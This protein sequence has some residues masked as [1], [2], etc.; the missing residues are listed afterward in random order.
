MRKLM[1]ALASWMLGGRGALGP[2]KRWLASLFLRHFPG[3][4]TCAEF[5]AFILD[6]HEGALSER[7][8]RTFEFH[9]TICPTCRTQFTGY[10]RTIELGQKI[11][12]AE[13]DTLPEEVED[14]LINAI[15]AARFR[16]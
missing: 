13:A 14:E 6:Y 7:Q 9:F 15:I 11:F 12:T 2:T 1:I 10:L 4:I 16:S 3:Q 8:R 5:E